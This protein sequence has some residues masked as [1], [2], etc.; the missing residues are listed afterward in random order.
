MN[1]YTF[2]KRGPQLSRWKDNHV[3]WSNRFR[4]KY[5]SGWHNQL[6]HGCKLWGSISI[7]GGDIREWWKEKQYSGIDKHCF[8]PIEKKKLHVIYYCILPLQKTRNK[9]HMYNIIPSTHLKLVSEYDLSIM[10]VCLRLSPVK[11]GKF[12]SVFSV[13]L[14]HSH[15]LS[16]TYPRY[17]VTKIYKYFVFLLAYVL[18]FTKTWLKK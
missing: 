1:I 12:M 18:N 4:E 15:T 10:F 13:S 8:H 17:T 16:S 2:R 9:I 3:C 5:L 14:E 11:D 7:Y 6:Y